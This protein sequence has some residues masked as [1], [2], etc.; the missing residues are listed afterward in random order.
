MTKQQI[1]DFCDRY[2]TSNEIGAE[3]L[4]LARD[5]DDAAR[6]W[7]EPTQEE[8]RVIIGRAFGKSDKETLFWG[9]SRLTLRDS[10]RDPL[11]ASASDD[12]DAHYAVLVLNEYGR[13]IEV[14]AA[15]NIMDDDIR[16]ELHSEIAPCS[17]VNFFRAYCVKHRERHGEDF[18]PNK[19]NPVW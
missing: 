3:I 7:A 8:C 16:E 5:D 4:N 13:E 6:I 17:P 10:I 15:I 2:E 12:P 9:G 1:R 18:E 11:W 14:G 19:M